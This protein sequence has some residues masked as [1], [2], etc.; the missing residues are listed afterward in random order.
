MPI[1]KIR[2]LP[3]KITL[4]IAGTLLS[5][6]LT[7]IV[8]LAAYA[9]NTM[10]TQVSENTSLIKQVEENSRVLIAQ[11]QTENQQRHAATMALIG[12][13]TVSVAVVK[14]TIN[15]RTIQ[16][17]E[18]TDRILDRMNEL[19]SELRRQRVEKPR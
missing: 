6:G 10:E 8:G 18:R 11:M 14:E 19:I 12:E 2:E 9:W 5:A 15:Q 4:L 3:L 13:I 1:E 17:D 16:Q 7:A